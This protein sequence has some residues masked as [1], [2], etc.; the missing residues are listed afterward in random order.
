MKMAFFSE[1]KRRNVYRVAALYIIVSWLILQITDVFTSFMPLPEWTGR[2]I[3]LLLLVG[4]PIALIFAW[5]F[6]LTPEGVKRERSGP[7]EGPAEGGKRKKSDILIVALLLAIVAYFA[8]QHD[9]RND[10][11]K[12]NPGEIDSIV[13]LPFDNLMNDPEQAYFVAGM[14]NALISELSRIDAL[15]VISRT[16]AV[17]FE[18][19]GKS[20][21]EIARELGVDAVVEGSVLKAGDTVRITVQL[22][23]AESDRH[24]WAHSFDRQLSNILKLYSEVTQEIANQVRVTL[25]PEEKAHIEVSGQVNPEVYKLYLKGRYLCDNWSPQEM[26]QGVQLL[27]EAVQLDPQNAPAHAQLALCLQYSAFFGYVQPSDIHARSKQAA[28]TAVQLDDQLAEAQVALAGILYYLDFNPRGAIEALD[29][30]LRLNPSSVRALLHA[31]WLLG[32]AGRF[33][34]AFDY[35]HRALSLD[36][37]STVVTHAAGQLH[38]LGRDYQN[39][40]IETGKAL[41]LDMSDPSLHYFLALPYEQ[42]GRLDEAI[43]SHQKAIELS[44]GVSIYLAALGHT[45]GLAERREEAAEI[46]GTLEEDPQTAP[47][48]IAIVYLGM[49]DHQ[50][51]IDWLEKAYSTRNSQ[52]IYINRDP[53]FDPL[54]EDSR[55]V[56]LLERFDFP[57]GDEP[58]NHSE[59]Q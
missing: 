26:Q 1:L 55:F 53:R 16:S 13:V 43:E 19:S 44:G 14:H 4:F 47:Y 37:L 58:L 21:P 52:L 24:I 46:L 36:P 56:Q 32:E 38:Y 6:E 29:K 2:L 57:P 48:D 39:A 12:Q 50:R 30:A 18:N 23:E 35:Y 10:H 42:T 34:E 33:E 17:R 51:A 41:E 27:E 20:V 11:V 8:W 25:T 40:I 9:W 3:F 45:F 54:R 31:S 28:E 49:G 15:R 5:A 59:G 7:P 22:I